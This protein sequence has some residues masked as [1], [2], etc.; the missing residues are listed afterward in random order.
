MTTPATTTLM[1]SALASWQPQSGLALTWDNS[2]MPPF[3]VGETL[4]SWPNGFDVSPT[5]GHY[6][7]PRTTGPGTS[8]TLSSYLPPST[9][10]TTPPPRAFPDASSMPLPVPQCPST[11]SG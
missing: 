6:S 3:P 8:P 11:P 2:Q 4:A 5:E 7:M 9:S 10:P 1:R